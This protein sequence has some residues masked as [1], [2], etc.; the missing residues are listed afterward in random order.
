MP[1]KPETAAAE[2]APDLPPDF[3]YDGPTVIELGEIELEVD[4]DDRLVVE[5]DD[6][7]VDRYR[8][9]D[10]IGSTVSLMADYNSTT[11]AE[12]RGR[13]VDAARREAET[14]AAPCWPGCMA[15]ELDMVPVFRYDKVLVADDRAALSELERQLRGVDGFAPRS[16][17]LETATLRD[18]KVLGGKD[19][20][21]R[22]L[23]P[24]SDGKPITVRSVIDPAERHCSLPDEACGSLRIA[25]GKFSRPS[26]AP[27]VSDR[28]RLLPGDRVQLVRVDRDGDAFSFEDFVPDAEAVAQAR[29]VLS[30]GDADRAVASMGLAWSAEFVSDLRAAADRAA[31]EFEH[32]EGEGEGEGEGDALVVKGTRRRDPDEAF[33]P[34]SVKPCKAN[35]ERL[36]AAIDKKL[37]ALK[38]P[39]AAKSGGGGGDGEG[40]GDDVVRVYREPGE[41]AADENNED[42]VYGPEYDDTPRAILARAAALPEQGRTL[43]ERIREA[44]ATRLSRAAVADIA[45]GGKRI[46]VGQRV[47]LRHS[48]VE[49][50]FMRAREDKTGRLFW[51]LQTTRAA[52]SAAKG[53]GSREMSKPTRGGYDAPPSDA[54]V[55]E[56]Q[57]DVLEAAAARLKGAAKKFDPDESS[58]TAA[59]NAMT[60][61]GHY[62][63]AEYA[64]LFAEVEYVADRKNTYE[65]AFRPVALPPPPDAPVRPSADDRTT[66]RQ[67]AAAAL[68]AVLFPAG[69]RLPRQMDGAAWLVRL[70]APEDQRFA[71]LDAGGGT[72]P[73]R[74]KFLVDTALR[75][76]AV[77]VLLSDATA[78]DA[79]LMLARA[80]VAPFLESAKAAEAWAAAVKKKLTADDIS[81]EAA[82][83]RLRS[84]LL[85]HVAEVMET[86]EDRVDEA[87][88]ELVKASRLAD[89]PGYRPLERDMGAPEPGVRLKSHAPPV[90]V[91]A[92]STAKL[93]AELARQVA[94]ALKRL[95]LADTD[96]SRAAIEE[97]LRAPGRD[98]ARAVRANVMATFALAGK[99]ASGTTAD[100]SVARFKR[101]SGAEARDLLRRTASLRSSPGS[102]PGDLVRTWLKLAEEAGP[103]ISAWMAETLAARLRTAATDVDALLARM[104]AAKEAIKNEKIEF[105]ETVIDE[106]TQRTMAELRK[107]GL[108][109]VDEQIIAYDAKQKLADR[110][111]GLGYDVPPAEEEGYDTMT[112]YDDGGGVDFD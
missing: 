66:Y 23:L 24:P 36:Q 103:D 12:R 68:L 26:G 51:A 10:F 107:V 80:D 69:V 40:D 15:S 81:S 85:D 42:A 112:A 104:A 45:R 35:I 64:T 53:K 109:T 20:A 62:G 77:A 2:N 46:A 27:A 38:R 92:R 78:A 98:G 95:G 47:A 37:A 32:G 29:G 110:E 19:R 13:L 41:L 79:E 61:G 52:G 111:A 4:E 87:D 101:T 25:S 84:P 86:S 17:A 18:A 99:I 108:Q 93:D 65:T 56:F 1:P 73:L 105:F 8:S 50:V 28:V 76:A 39:S 89:W 22:P 67:L 71:E 82:A 7:Y 9:A 106:D 6:A 33:L 91:D 44:A 60:D 54:D 3:D 30:P 97:F 57:R 59:R 43:E 74:L 11:V 21:W 102:E 49:Q 55:A 63:T 5:S 100:E 58:V 94:T 96:A 16:L 14:D 88:A 31:E 70:T 75:A 90:A 34:A 83:L 48:G 72:D